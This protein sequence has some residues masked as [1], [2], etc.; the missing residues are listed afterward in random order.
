MPREEAESLERRIRYKFK[1]R[2]LLEEALTHKS[3]AMEK[4]GK[5]FNERL[6]FLGDSIVNAVVAHYFFKRFPS[7]DEGRLSKIKSQ[8]VA[9]PALAAWARAIG[10]GKYLWMSGGEE[11]T[12]G[13]DRD[14]LLA[15]AF[16]ALVGAIFLE[17]GFP[18]AQRFIVRLLA[19]HKRIVEN[20]YKSKLQ[21]LIQKRYK[22][23]PLYVVAE[24]SGPDHAKT[25]LMEVRL[26]RRLLGQGTGP[27]KKQAEQ[28]AAY[29]ALK[30]LRSRE[31]ISKKKSAEAGLEKVK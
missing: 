5:L 15:N 21:E 1:N 13:R 26:R 14:S 24:E 30:K 28:A 19:K 11:A 18:A 8:M 16:E 9:R 4:G 12:G 6:E 27:S 17:S 25:F 2:K 29:E 20:D 22:I 23:P 7:N 3:H 10:M 31:K